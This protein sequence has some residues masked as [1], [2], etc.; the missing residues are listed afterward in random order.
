MF[1]AMLVRENAALYLLC[2]V[3]VTVSISM[4]DDVLDVQNHFSNVFQSLA[5]ICSAV[6]EF[7]QLLMDCQFSILVSSFQ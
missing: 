6:E 7:K 4:A 3:M 5:F 1:Y 2:T